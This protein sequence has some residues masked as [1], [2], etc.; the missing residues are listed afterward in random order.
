MNIQYFGWSGILLEHLNT[1]VAVDLFGDAVGWDSIPDA[2]P[3]VLCATH[4]HP[5]HCGSLRRL[6]SEAGASA[7]R[8]DVHLVSSPKVVSYLQRFASLPPANWHSVEHSQRVTIGDLSLRVFDWRH[9][10]LLPPGLGPKVEYAVQLLRHPVD[11]VR[12]G[13]SSLTLPHSAPTIGFY[14][15]FS[16]GLRVLNYAEG[17]HRLT[18]RREVEWVASEM[19]ADVLLFAVEPDDTEDIPRWIDILQPSEVYIYEAHRPW[20]DL[21]HLPYLNL[22]TYREE[23]ARRFPMIRFSALLEPLA[24]AR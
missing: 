22:E 14:A 1:V 4:G 12:I 5:E 15:C 17:L 23:L 6:L 19:P 18:D 20:R 11:F 16:D 13:T 8:D 9:M 21:F 24:E 3:I 7:Q 10:P 2:M